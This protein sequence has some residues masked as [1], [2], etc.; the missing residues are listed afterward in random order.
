MTSL[1]IIKTLLKKLR[2]HAGSAPALVSH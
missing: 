1:R 2:Q